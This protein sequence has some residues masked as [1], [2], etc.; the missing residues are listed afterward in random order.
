[1]AQCV[2]NIFTDCCLSGLAVADGNIVDT[3]DWFTGAGGW[4]RPFLQSATPYTA[5]HAT[6]GAILY[7]ILRD[8][9]AAFFANY[10]FEVIEY[11]GG[12]VVCNSGGG[13]FSETPFEHF[14]GDVFVTMYG[15][16]AAMFLLAVAK[17][18]EPK[19][20]SARA[21]LGLTGLFVLYL[22]M[23]LLCQLE[24]IPESNA[25]QGSLAFAWVTLLAFHL[26]TTIILWWI[27]PLVQEEHFGVKTPVG[28]AA[29]SVLAAC[30]LGHALTASIIF[31][32]SLVWVPASVFVWSLIA[33]GLLLFAQ[34]SARVSTRV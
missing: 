13:Y 11:I 32:P 18:R 8:W 16:T 24:P 12:H 14:L 29:R 22:G 30:Y 4:I 7:L 15:A 2:S 21:W 25:E 6:S 23:S 27:V 34:A 9:Y 5:I 10:I 31:M 28:A 20:L 26:P 19:K 3:S 1:M 17:A 33:Y